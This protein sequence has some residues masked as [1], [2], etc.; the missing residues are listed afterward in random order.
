MQKTLRALAFAA[1][2]G[3]LASILVL[4]IVLLTNGIKIEYAGDVRVLGMPSEIALR[5]AEPATITIADGA[6]ITAA[7]A[8]T[9]DAPVGISFASALCPT[10]GA[11]ML[12]VRYDVLTGKIEWA[13]PQCTAPK[14]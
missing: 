13:C 1:L 14:P 3:L 12:P 8:G 4:L 11:A 7:V 5:I 2:L 6:T 10:C 9:R